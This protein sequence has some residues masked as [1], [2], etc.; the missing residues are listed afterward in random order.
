MSR[1]TQLL[2]SLGILL[3]TIGGFLYVHSENIFT[4]KHSEEITDSSTPTP[5]EVPYITQHPMQENESVSPL[6]PVPT[7][8]ISI[9]QKNAELNEY[10]NSIFSIQYPAT[11]KVDRLDLGNILYDSIVIYNPSFPSADN[12]TGGYPLRSIFIKVRSFNEQ[13]P[14]TFTSRLREAAGLDQV[15]MKR[16]QVQQIK[17]GDKM[18]ETNVVNKDDVAFGSWFFLTNNKYYVSLLLPNGQPELQPE[19]QILSSFTFLK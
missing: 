19:M 10:S 15:E 14:G 1:T 12:R 8:S 16:I 3:I 9:K 17:V 18:L 2:I 6:V 7:D 4:Q 5:T 13:T 11:W